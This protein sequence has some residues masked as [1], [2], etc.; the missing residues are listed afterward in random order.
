MMVRLPAVAAL[1]LLA[2][3]VLAQNA[4]PRWVADANTGCKVWD[5][6][7][8]PD[9]GASWSGACKNGMADGRGTLQW[10]DNGQ[11]VERDEGEFRDG[12]M[13]GHGVRSFPGG[14][15]YEGEWRDSQPNG[16]GVYGWASG[17][18][19]DGEWLNNRR[20]G[21]GTETFANGDRYDGQWRNDRPDGQGILRTS[22]KQIYDGNW[23]GGCFKD[24][25][26]QASVITTRQQCG[27]E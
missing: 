7:P 6:S 11:P 21:T 12:K 15:R 10:L 24:G 9:D 22:D 18:R 2:M 4:Q 16:R 19:Y 8:G 14:S 13:T 25:R 26:R 1:L 23:T 27:F 5:A 17:N 20:H 3:P